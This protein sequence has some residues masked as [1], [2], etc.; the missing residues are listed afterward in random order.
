MSRG[1]VVP[2]APPVVNG[3]ETVP[4]AV[5]LGLGVITSTHPQALSIS[6]DVNVKSGEDSA[7]AIALCACGGA[8]D[9]YVV[10]IGSIKETERLRETIKAV[11][12]DYFVGPSESRGELVDKL[13]ERLK[14]TRA[15]R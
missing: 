11:L 5:K 8:F 1:I 10:P 14:G 3:W 15:V 4:G 13:T 2:T 9:V 12:D 7:R 6:M